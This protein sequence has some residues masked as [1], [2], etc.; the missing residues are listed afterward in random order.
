MHEFLTMVVISPDFDQLRLLVCYLL[1]NDGLLT[2]HV[3]CFS[4]GIC[5][6]VH[7]A[8]VE[9]KLHKRSF[10]AKHNGGPD[11]KHSRLVC[12]WQVAFESKPTPALPRYLSN[13]KINTS[14]QSKEKPSWQILTH[15][16][17]LWFF[18]VCSITHYGKCGR[19]VTRNFKLFLLLLKALARVFE[20]KIHEHKKVRKGEGEPGDKAKV[21][22][23]LI[24]LGTC[25]SVS[26]LVACTMS[27]LPY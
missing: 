18:L 25:L 6:Q 15:C 12:F 22:A 13:N 7:R 26:Q 5:S 9:Q 8:F 16:F 27:S 2:L 10:Y 19:T 24:S 11:S 23:C 1:N 20:Y 4:V 3:L 17:H 21:K 14:L